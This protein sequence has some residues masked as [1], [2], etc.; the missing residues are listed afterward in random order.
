MEKVCCLGCAGKDA[1]ESWHLLP[2]SWGGDI[3]K[4]LPQARGK[5]VAGEPGSASWR[6]SLS[7]PGPSRD[8]SPQSF[9]PLSS[10]TVNK[11]RARGLG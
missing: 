4:E 6:P 2:S 9:S 10:L 7:L 11:P 5:Y 3:W 1:R 8:Q